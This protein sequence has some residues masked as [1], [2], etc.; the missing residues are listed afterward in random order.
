MPSN[1]I[2]LQFDCRWRCLKLSTTCDRAFYGNVY[3][4]L[5]NFYVIS[6]HKECVASWNPSS[7]KTRT[8]SSDNTIAAG[9]MVT[10]GGRSSAAKVLPGIPRHRHQQRSTDFIKIIQIVKLWW[11]SLVLIY[12]FYRDWECT[13]WEQNQKE[14]K[15]EVIESVKTTS[16]EIES[17]W[18][19]GKINS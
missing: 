6:W 11:Y 7:R 10:H 17:R 1:H 12:F 5:L 18:A 2:I 9:G 15:Q 13:T 3:V 14:K 4:V 8:G 16:M 19:V